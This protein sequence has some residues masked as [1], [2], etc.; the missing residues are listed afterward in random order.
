MQQQLIP[1]DIIRRILPS[2]LMVFLFG[3]S[4][5]AAYMGFRI[6]HLYF[7]TLDWVETP[8]RLVTI[9]IV[10]EKKKKYAKF[11]TAAPANNSNTSSYRLRCSL[12]YNYTVN[13][14]WYIGNYATVLNRY[15]DADLCHDL[16]G[17]RN[18]NSNMIS[19]FYNPRRPQNS[20]RSTQLPMRVMAVYILISWITGAVAPSKATLL[21]FISVVYG[22]ISAA[23]LLWIAVIRL[24][25][26]GI[27]LFV[28]TILA[29]S[30]V[31]K[32]YIGHS[33]CNTSE[34]EGD[35]NSS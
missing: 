25:R 8:A 3:A 26:K 18:N 7:K 15:G 27:E 5:V 1:R 32:P 31:L 13:G 23:I 33:Y 30:A 20:A 19:C 16:H 29:V 35:T 4:V 28:G 9:N 24:P 11:D 22:V 21:K 6:V 10:K 34:Y 2:I 17:E 14:R 12:V